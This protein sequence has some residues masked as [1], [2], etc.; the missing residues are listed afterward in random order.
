MIRY[1][2]LALGLS[3]GAAIAA[4]APAPTTPAALASAYVAAQHD[5][6]AAALG[7]LTAPDFVEISPV[8]EVDPRDAVLGFYAADK[9]RPAPPMMLTE[10]SVRSFGDTGIVTA[11]LS[12][13]P[14]AVRVVYVAQRGKD[15]W[16]LVSA[17][18]TPIRAKPS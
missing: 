1:A 2:A 12:F 3:A 13:G 8:G 6:D 10:Q 14:G 18:Y 4:P 9:R 7:A 16:K 17:Q 5:F 11:R 15:G